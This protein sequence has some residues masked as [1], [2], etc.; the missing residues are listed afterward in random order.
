MTQLV[1]FSA[2]SETGVGLL[3]ARLWEDT[4]AV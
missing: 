4:G 2:A 3:A 1:A